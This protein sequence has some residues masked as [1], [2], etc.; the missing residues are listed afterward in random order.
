MQGFIHHGHFSHYLC[1]KRLDDEKKNK[2]GLNCETSHLPTTCIFSDI[3]H[4]FTGSYSYSLTEKMDMNTKNSQCGHDVSA[5]VHRSLRTGFLDEGNAK[6]SLP[7][8]RTYAADEYISSKS[9]GGSN[10]RASTPRPH[11]FS[12]C[13]EGW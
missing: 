9:P 11:Y 4:I 8:P 13:Q 5:A 1:A 2:S 12:P 6:E 3:L 7:F 10:R